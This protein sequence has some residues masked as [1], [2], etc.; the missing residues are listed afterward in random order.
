ME[1]NHEI[2][3]NSLGNQQA[4]DSN[5]DPQLQFPWF[6]SPCLESSQIANVKVSQDSVLCKSQKL[7]RADRKMQKITVKISEPETQSEL[8][9]LPIVPP[10]PPVI[11]PPANLMSDDEGDFIKELPESFVGRGDVSGIKFTQLRKTDLA[12]IYQVQNTGS[13]YY[14]I[15]ERRVNT[16]FGNISYPGSEAFGRWAWTTSDLQK[17]LEIFDALNHRRIEPCV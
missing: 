12:Y 6:N 5:F 16:Q 4:K 9:F 14:E 2:S 15:F 13:V 8:L 11:E 3:P 7:D 17:A 10:L 1:N